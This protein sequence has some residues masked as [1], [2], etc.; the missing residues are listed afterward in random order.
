[1]FN[2]LIVED[3]RNMR[4][5]IKTVLSRASYNCYTAVDGVQALEVMDS[6]HIDLAV[7]DIMMPNL[8]G[9]EFTKALRESGCNIPVLM[10][11]A[12]ISNEDKRQGFNSG[13]DDFLAK[14]FD[15][16]E[17][18]WRIKALLRRSKIT[19]EKVL[20]I[21][22]T[23]LDYSSFTATVN[24][25][26]AELTPKEFL[27]LYKLLSCPNR[28][29]TKRQIMDEIWNFDT[30]SDEH[31]VE[32][33]INRLREKFKNNRDFSIKTIRGFGYMG[34]IEDEKI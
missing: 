4:E 26:K 25:E 29:F 3:D 13:T 32:V 1:M 34:I 28:L 22:S 5:L 31:T 30:E 6:S 8:N 16:D 15:N 33:H 20:E 24:G 7:V 10:V 23:R 18:L 9:Y 21:G 2:I 12:K 19:S 14:P 17:L 11:T 27:L